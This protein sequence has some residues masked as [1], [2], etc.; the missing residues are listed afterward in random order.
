MRSMKQDKD[1]KVVSGMEGSQSFDPTAQFHSNYF[2]TL[3]NV[4]AGMK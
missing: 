4:V 1:A 2:T 3:A